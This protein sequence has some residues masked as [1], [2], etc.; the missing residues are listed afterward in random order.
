VVV[1]PVAP[2]D[3]ARELDLGERLLR[4]PDRERRDAAVL[5][6]SAASAEES[7]PPESSTPTGTSATRCARTE[8]RRPL[9]Q[10]VGER[11]PRLVA[12]LQ[13]GRSSA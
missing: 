6:A 5:G 11:L 13:R 2:R 1:G 10:L 12:V 4:E 9:A 8:S 7:T 3:R